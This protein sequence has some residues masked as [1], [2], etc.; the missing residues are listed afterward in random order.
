M[1]TKILSQYQTSH[2]V[3]FERCKVARKCLDDLGSE[4]LRD[5]PVQLR[6]PMMSLSAEEFVPAAKA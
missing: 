1:A 6:G 3:W 5:Y 2:N 4:N